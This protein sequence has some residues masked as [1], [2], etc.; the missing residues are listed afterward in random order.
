VQNAI[1]HAFTARERG[2]IIVQLCAQAG[3]YTVIVEDDGIGN[4]Q[5]GN[6]PTG[7]GLQIIETLVSDDLKGA[8]E[9]IPSSGGTKAIIRFPGA[10]A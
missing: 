8:F 7:L 5:A 1:E 2:Q 4:Y 9:I 3:E 10:L 6:A